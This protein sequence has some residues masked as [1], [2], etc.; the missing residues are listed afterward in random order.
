MLDGNNKNAESD[1][2]SPLSNK[3]DIG[4]QA[5]QTTTEVCYLWSGNE[6][7]SKSSKDSIWD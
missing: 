6:K 1:I 5:K 2:G 4:Q 7:N 3:P